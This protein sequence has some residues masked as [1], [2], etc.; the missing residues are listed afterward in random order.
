MNSP[1]TCRKYRCIVITDLD[2]S[3]LDRETYSYEA[4]LPVIE[5]LKNNGIPI[6]F[7]SSKTRVEQEYFRKRL[8]IDD[9]FIVENGAA[10]Y[11]PRGYFGISVSEAR[12]LGEYLVIEL[13]IPIE[14]LLD[15]SRDLIRKYEGRVKWVHEMSAEEVMEIT[16]L[17]RDQAILAKQR[18]YSL[19]FYP[20]DKNVIE[21]LSKDLVKKGL[22]A[23]TGGGK[24]YLVT[25]RH[26]KGVAVS[27]L[28]DLYK[29]LYPQVYTIGIG[30]NLNDIPMLK[31]VDQP[32]VLDNK[33]DPREHGLPSNTIVIDIDGSRGWRK[34]IGKIFHI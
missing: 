6:V 17:P 3:L 28:V 11:I 31:N 13:G 27:K 9:P 32:I 21:P 15:T 5:Y 33:I 2:G 18:E 26:D 20:L 14:K 8:G 23:S 24:L 29:R 16:G 7:C 19:A 22:I 10:I 30:D 4:A 12:D 1:Y 25:G 34:A